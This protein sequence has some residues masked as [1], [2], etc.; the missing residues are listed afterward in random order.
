MGFKFGTKSKVKLATC[1][2]DIQK[3]LNLAIS[4]SKVDFG[5]SEGTRSLAK[6]QEYYAIGR[7]VDKHKNTI[8][9][10]DGVTKKGKHN[11]SPSLAV[12]IYVWHS[13][14]STRKKISYDEAHLSYVAGVIDSCAAELN[15]KLK[16]G[17]NWDGDGIIKFDQNLND[18]PHYEIK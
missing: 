10:V 16:W 6:Q 14:S 2:R 17:G 12:D 3:V 4:R 18:M 8:T 15:I 1:H 13:N 11:H 7:T 9:N 5:I